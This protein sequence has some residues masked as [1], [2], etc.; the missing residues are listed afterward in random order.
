MR[1]TFTIWKN[2]GM[3][4]VLIGLLFV[5]SASAG[6]GQVVISQVYGGGGNTGAT[7]THDF[8]ELFNRGSSVVSLNGLSIQY[9]SATGTGNFSTNVLVLPNINLNPGQYY[10]IQMA[11]GAVG[12]PLPVPD[13]IGTINMAAGAGKVVLVDGTGGLACNGGSTVCD[14]DQ[15]ARIIDLVGYGNANF[16]EGSGAAPTLSNTTA[17][18]RI[19]GGCTDTDNNAADF[20]AAAPNPRNTASTLNV[21][22]VIPPPDPVATF[23]ESGYQ[24]N[25]D[26]FTGAGFS[27]NPDPGQLHSGNWRVTGMSDG[28]GVFGGTHITGDF[29]RGSSTGGVTTGGLYA[30]DVGGGTT[31][32]GV[33]PGGTDFTP[34]AFTLRLENTSGKTVEFL[35]LEYDIYVLNDQDRSNSFNFAF[36]FDDISYTAVPSLNYTTPAAADA[37]PVWVKVERSTTISG[38]TFQHG[39]FIYFQWQSGD[40]GGSGSRDEFGLTKINLTEGEAPEIADPVFSVSAGTY[41]ENQTVFISN[42]DDYDSGVQVY[43]TTDG[44]DPDDT[45]ALYDDDPGIL[46]VDGNGPVTLKAI[47]KDAANSLESEITSALY[48]FPVNV[49]DIAAFRSGTSGVLYRITGQV[50]VLHRDGFRN[51][52]FVRDGSGSLTIWDETTPKK[53]GTEYSVGDGVANF[54]GVRA[55]KNTNGLV[56]MEAATDPGTAASTGQDTSPISITL[57]DLDFDHT[58]NL[59]LIS[60]VEFQSGGSFANGQNYQITDPSIAEA[61]TFRTDF[62]NVDYIGTLVPV[63]PGNLTAIVGGFGS[64]VQVT[65]RD[66]TDLDFP[67]TLNTPVFDPPAGT[68]YTDQIVFI[69]NFG[70]YGPDVNIYYTTDGPEP[71]DSSSLYDDVTGILLEQTNGTVTLQ[72][73]AIDTENG[74]QSQV[75]AGIYSFPV[76]NEVANIGELRAGN[77]DGTLYRLTGEVVLTLQAALRNQKFIQ[78]ASGAIMI[79]DP[80]G[81]ITTTYDLGDGITGITGMLGAFE[82][83]LQFVPV[84]DP[85]TATSTG[86]EITPLVVA[87]DELGPEHQAM[88]VT[89]YGVSF[90]EA[91]WGEDFE[92]GITY[93][94]WDASGL[95]LLRTQYG[96]LDYLDPDPMVIPEGAHI[97][98]VIRQFGSDIQ[99]TPRSMDDFFK[100]FFDFAV[101]PPPVEVIFGTDLAGAIAALPTKTTMEDHLGNV[102]EVEIIDWVITDYDGQTPGQYL[103]TGVVVLPPWIADMPTKDNGPVVETEIIVLDEPVAIPLSDWALILVM[104]GML[105]TAVWKFRRH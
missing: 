55:M 36:S 100:T 82:N 16:F 13:A 23:T 69:S 73:I 93:D 61:M 52:H 10:L 21:C 62:F 54:T 35:D 105:L 74:Q 65:A 78:D 32:M 89:V 18:I 90:D 22:P 50:V 7:Y 17:A 11:G 41:F 47:A 3:V 70:D 49:G 101:N 96:D 19:D 24:E 58:G 85:G 92:V 5:I 84:A 38:L 63:L 83:M 77:T 44:T 102:F 103:A 94:I 64:A 88:L 29:A 46:L 67:E 12:D 26:G 51:R 20:S 57:D 87:L 75:A 14:A 33:Q 79:D 86:L 8:V 53:I 34:G 68:Y 60:D 31:I 56:V 2:P 99:I 97:T 43:Y 40:A 71:D 95:G 30:F 66:L 15:L 28:N 80:T 25:F 6:W 37:E 59:V 27:P 72:A 9:T 104:G 76:I 42:Y 39:D 45:S 1:K 91:D 48:T 98:G 4:S 81:V